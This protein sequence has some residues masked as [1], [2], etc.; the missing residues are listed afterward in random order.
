MRAP[1]DPVKKYLFIAFGLITLF[2]LIS[3]V[4]SVLLI[5]EKLGRIT[6]GYVEAVA[7]ILLVFGPLLFPCWTLRRH[8]LNYKFVN[9]Q[10]QSFA[11][12]FSAK[13]RKWT[14][15]RLSI[16]PIHSIPRASI[17]FCEF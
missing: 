4:G 14:I 3:Y 1:V 7:D 17:K 15:P 10:R 11:L 12:I 16:A 13:P 9:G 2:L 6:N 5:G 8:F